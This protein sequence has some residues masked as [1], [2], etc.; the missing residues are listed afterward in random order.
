MK[1][2][3]IGVFLLTG[4]AMSVEAAVLAQNFYGCR[5]QADARKLLEFLAKA[6]KSSIEKLGKAKIAAGSC[7]PIERGT[8]VAVD[9]KK[10]SLFCV[11]LT[12]GLDCYWVA[13]ALIDQ[14]AHDAQERGSQKPNTG[15][16][17]FPGNQRNPG[18]SP[19]QSGFNTGGTSGLSPNGFSKDFLNN[20][21]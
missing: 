11:R 2:F 14:K 21:R 8:N 18:R 9:E 5:D 17:D 16:N 4:Q 20:G 1:L 15:S 10:P 12:G 19:G 6:D 13:D 3:W 7:I